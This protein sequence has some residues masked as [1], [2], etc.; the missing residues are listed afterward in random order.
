MAN[1]I[2]AGNSSNGGTA[3]VTDT[4]G[5]LNIVTG[6]GSGATA[7]SVDTSQNVG[8]GATTVGA[9]LHVSQ[10][11]TT[12]GALF[13]GTTRAIRFGFDTTGS[14]IEG[15]DNTGVTSFQP[16]SVGGAD[17]RFTT[18]GTERAR[19]DSSGNLL[20]NSTSVISAGKICATFAGN[21]N[22]GIDL[23][24]TFASNTGTFVGFFNSATALAGTINQ[25][26]AT[27]VAYGTSSDYRLKE[28]VQPMTG[29]LAKVA[30]LKPCTYNWKIDGSNGQGFIAHELQAVVP[31]CVIGT[32]DAVN[33]NGDAQYQSIDTSFLVA[34]L[35][36]AIQELKAELD[37]LK[38]KVGE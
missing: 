24:N 5:T 27:T 23:K 33:E 3:I 19:I 38:A 8:I 18:S 34:T 1:S 17:V 35:T 15:V 20:V 30:Q 36:A 25:T 21:V 2:T 22:N 9:K 29:A 6:S 4:S 26:G 31:D 16:L 12:V 28:N 13:N 32:K 10:V 7:I 37:A 11:N 14:I